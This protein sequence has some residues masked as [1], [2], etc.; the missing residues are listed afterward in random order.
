MEFEVVYHFARSYLMRMHFFEHHYSPL[1]VDIL[2]ADGPKRELMAPNDEPISRKRR[3]TIV[4]SDDNRP[5][6][7]EIKGSNNDTKN[8]R[9]MARIRPFSRK[10]QDQKMVLKATDASIVLD[11][12]DD[13]KFDYDAVLGPTSTQWNVY[14]QSGARDAVPLCGDILQGFNCTI[15]AY[16]QTGSGKTCKWGNFLE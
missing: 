14:H 16:G 13:R 6:G 4:P 3:R 5:P 8:V 7:F 10:E 15:L 12:G 1:P 11:N 2:K 9:V